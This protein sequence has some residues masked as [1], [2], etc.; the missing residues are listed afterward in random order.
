MGISS[1]LDVSA[2][3]LTAERVWMDV[4]S[5]NIANANTTRT[6]NGLPY[7]REEVIFESRGGNSFRS[8]LDSMRGD[9]IS[10]SPGEGVKVA[11]IVSDTSP[12]RRVYM[13]GSPDADKNG[14]VMMPNV[15][16]VME[17]VNLI[18]SNRAYDAGVTA[19]NA[20]KQMQVKA[21]SI[22]QA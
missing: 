2:S 7:R 16:P 15:Q 9:P 3:G 14:Y 13:P 6:A 1:S 11:A 19:M 8:I 20:A 17:M 10:S 12:F 18:A 22:G 4:I 21:L 5:N